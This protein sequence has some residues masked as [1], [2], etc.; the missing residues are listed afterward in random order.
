MD[1]DHPALVFAHFFGGSARSWDPLLGALGDRHECIVPDLPGF[2]DTPPLA[3]ASLDAYAADLAGRAEGRAWIAVGHSMGGKIALAAAQRSPTLVG[4]VLIAA[5]PPT[6]QP[7]S[8]ADRQAS[9]AAFGNREAAKREF[10]R[11]APHLAEA[12]RSIAADDA[13]RVARPAWHWWLEQ[14]SRDDI[15]PSM[16]ALT[17]PVLVITGDAD[18][19]LG[20]DTAASIAHQ[21]PRATLRTVAGAG[22]MVPLEQPHLVARLVR[23]FRADISMRAA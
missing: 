18:R 21:L 6:P 8:D 1:G 23:D 11:I 5:S 20:P 7:M 14:G 19:V 16:K 9:L 4:I 22:H 15:S 10:A 2:G 12:L 17:L 3:S 13:L